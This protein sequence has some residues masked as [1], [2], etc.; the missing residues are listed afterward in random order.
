MSLI[1]EEKTTA[2]QCLLTEIIYYIYSK[3]YKT[4]HDLHQSF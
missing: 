3:N 4:F 1:I 2:H